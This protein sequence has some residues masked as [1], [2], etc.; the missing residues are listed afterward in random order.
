MTDVTHDADAGL[1][2]HSPVSSQT[3]AAGE[4][5][6]QDVL[7]DAPSTGEGGEVVREP[8]ASWR[9]VAG[10]GA[11][12]AELREVSRTLEGP[13]PIGAASYGPMVAEAVLG[14]DDRIQ[15]NATHDYPWRAHAS[16]LVVARDGS[17]W[18]GTGWFIGP[19][20][21]ATAGHVVYIKNSGVPRTVTAG[22]RASRS[23]PGATGPPCRTGRSPPR[24]SGRSP[25]GRQQR[26]PGVRL[27]RD[28]P[29]DR[30]RRARPAGSASG[31]T[32]TRRSTDRR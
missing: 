12:A 21:L 10:G 5:D 22:C 26:E 25:A 15:I 14:R 30:P 6:E 23:C 2:L 11:E 4:Q 8:P 17:R 27:R 16:L 3:D 13:L 24:T 28:R 18:I 20:T 7:T 31:P 19:H 32:R 29:A 1:D 9:R